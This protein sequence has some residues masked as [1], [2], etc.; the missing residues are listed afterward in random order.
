M[1][2]QELRRQ[3]L[4]GK[5]EVPVVNNTWSELVETED[6]KEDKRP[7]PWECPIK[8]ESVSDL[9]DPAIIDSLVDDRRYN[10]KSKKAMKNFR[11]F[12]EEAVELYESLEFQ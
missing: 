1:S 5:Q 6:K 9:T 11:E 8:L 7:K 2:L 3:L 4:Y 10:Y 12:F